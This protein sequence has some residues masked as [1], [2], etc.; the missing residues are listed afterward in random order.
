[1]TTEDIERTLWAILSAMQERKR[2]T[3]AG[4]LADDLI[5]EVATQ[6]NA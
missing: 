5:E 2:E 3:G 6:G 4:S 1:M